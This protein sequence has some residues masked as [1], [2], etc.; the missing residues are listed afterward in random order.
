MIPPPI[1]LRLRSSDLPL[2]VVAAWLPSGDVWSWLRELAATPLP[3]GVR[4]FPVPTSAT[5]SAAGGVV[6]LPPSETQPVEWGARVQP[7]AWLAPRVLGPAGSRIFP[8]LTDSEITTLFPAPLQFLHPTLG[9]IAFWKEDAVRP[10]SLLLPPPAEEA[11]WNA[12]V[13]GPPKRPLLRQV[14]MRRSISPEDLM[15]GLAGDIGEK[16]GQPAVDPEA[17]GVGER[18]G[19]EAGRWLRGIAGGVLKSIEAVLPE[20]G[21]S[22]KRWIDDLLEWGEKHWDALRSRRQSEL[23]RLL[24]LLETNPEEGLRYAIPLAGGDAGR[25]VARPGASLGPRRTS[26]DW[27]G[28]GR[29]G[30]V[31]AW[32]IA[33]Q[34]QAE[35]ASRYRRAA[36]QE[37]EQGRHSRAAYIYGQL[38]GDWSSA[39]DALK[40]GG[41]HRDAAQICLSRLKDRR[42]AARFLEEGG[43]LT[44]ALPLY[45]ELKVH[46][47]CGELYERLGLQA[48]ARAAWAH[49]AAAAPTALGKAAILETKLQ[50]L[51]GA[52]VCLWSAWSRRHNA[53]ECM[54]E[55]FHVCERHQMRD[56]ASEML[57]ALAAAPASVPSENLMSVLKHAFSS[58][59][60]ASLRAEASRIGIDIIGRRLSGSPKPHESPVLL[61]ALPAFAPDDRLLARD[62]SRYKLAR[63]KPIAPAGQPPPMLRPVV[64]LVL[65]AGF[66]PLS[67]DSL[68]QWITL[69][70][71]EFNAE[72]TRHL[73]RVFVRHRAVQDHRLL[74]PVA[75]PVTSGAHV[76]VSSNDPGCMFWLD[77]RSEM[78]LSFNR[79]QPGHPSPRMNDCV[80][81]ARAGGAAEEL[82]VLNLTENGGPA[83]MY[84]DVQFNWRRT[85]PVPDAFP[86]G[87]GSSVCLA[88]RDELVWIASGASLQVMLRTQPARS[89]A[90]SGD[91]LSLTPAPV[92]LP[93]HA[94]LVCGNEAT[95]LW[96]SEDIR[97][98]QFVNLFQA[99]QGSPA[100]TFTRQGH[101]V[102]AA[103]GGGLLYA[104]AARARQVSEIIIPETA[105][106]MIG[107]CA[108]GPKGFALLGEKG[109]LLIYDI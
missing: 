9:R 95:L 104:L 54:C 62:A 41:L 52:L 92:H 22:Q 55:V 77:A 53:V 70:G 89:F 57:R 47:K 83:V 43:L 88:V 8:A 71:E 37:T 38:L 61:N 31:D 59:S 48:E 18:M 7:L 103:A 102:T 105:G 13:P 60:D 15:S 27:R 99:A 20:S 32:D 17:S 21:S 101:V 100:A 24:E 90:L 107:A 1:V 11:R 82:A 46:D 29:T 106:S 10:E 86:A 84:Y 33:A 19:K 94:V 87:V 49:A 75:E 96:A 36:A 69:L 80:A 23:N 34:T 67:M 78:I 40:N 68:G 79:E 28:T 39:A 2:P 91:I 72:G 64:D 108:F 42:R 85:R 93:P 30:P 81:L 25:G 44:E 12:A 97:K 5:C 3:P 74:W 51:E 109:R 56:R 73:A 65:P 66:R 4:L 16:A 26:L 63:N 58:T 98:M 76:Q 35:L 50:D 6:I 45:E 14:G